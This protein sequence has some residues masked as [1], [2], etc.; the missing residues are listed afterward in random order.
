MDNDLNDL[1]LEELIEFIQESGRQIDS[2]KD[3]RKQATLVYDKKVHVQEM[4][5]KHGADLTDDQIEQIDA[6]VNADTI[7]SKSEAK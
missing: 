4:R 7:V 3:Q 6:I 1:S 2:L 5:S